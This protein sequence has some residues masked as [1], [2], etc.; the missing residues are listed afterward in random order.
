MFRKGIVKAQ[1]GNTTV[2]IS[3][4]WIS[5]FCGMLPISLSSILMLR[6]NRLG[7]MTIRVGG[8][9]LFNSFF[10]WALSLGWLA[11]LLLFVYLY[12]NQKFLAR[13]QSRIWKHHEK[14]KI[15]EP[16]G[17]N[18]RSANPYYKMLRI[19]DNL[20]EVE[21][22][23]SE[24]FPKIFKENYDARLKPE[25]V[26]RTLLQKKVQEIEGPQG[27]FGEVKERK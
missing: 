25:Q 11:A 2:M 1:K 24:R 27:E 16:V 7:I 4:F 21:A 6:K 18:Y 14:G 19:L 3:V 10:L 8:K 17:R 13:V 15:M 26:G 22:N 9:H 12:T 23:R 20:E 5:V